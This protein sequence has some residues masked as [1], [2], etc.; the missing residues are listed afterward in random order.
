MEIMDWRTTQL[1]EI[2]RLHHTIDYTRTVTGRNILTQS[3]YAPPADPALIKEKQLA[4]EEIWSDT[5]LQQK[6]GTMVINVA[7]DE[8]LLAYYEHGTYSIKPDTDQ[9]APNLY[10]AHEGTTRFLGHLAHDLADVKPRTRY[11]GS[12]VNNLT[13]LREDKVLELVEGP[14]CKTSQGLKPKHEVERHTRYTEFK[15]QDIHIPTYFNKHYLDLIRGSMFFPIGLMFL[16]KQ[17]WLSIG[18]VPSIAANFIDPYALV[19]KKR[20]KDVTTFVDP[21]REIY[22]GNKNVQT[23][24]KSYGKIDELLSFAHYAN[25]LKG[26]ITL[27]EIYENPRHAFTATDLRNPI[28]ATYN[29]KYVGNDV[30]LAGPKLTFL[31]GPNTGGKTSLTKTILQTQLLA[32][33]GSYIP[34]K[35]AR[36]ST[37]D[38]IAYHSQML[39]TMRDTEGRFGTEIARTRDIFF[40]ATPKSIIALDELIEA[41]SHDEKLRHAT[42]ILEDFYTIGCNTILITHSI[43]LA[44]YFQSI[45]K[46]Q[47]QQIEFKN[48]KP[49]HKLIQGISRDSHS[50][51]V[52]KRVGFT[53]ED[54]QKHLKK[55]GYI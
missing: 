29:P 25:E 11:L 38:Y 10:K 31:T 55:M 21:L 4:I 52:V 46:G 43:D 48:G 6:I 9:Y 17:P 49:T 39:D 33:I 26:P 18:A 35:Q 47:F 40:K 50:D 5:N 28:D 30:D 34:A 45:K 19:V 54:R 2:E 16:F 24:L 7:R 36:M 1:L 3:I 53:V 13:A 22:F 37:A 41:T 32:Q 42:G 14:V 12:L 15:P 51:A 20:K 27:P 44:K 23:A 8:T